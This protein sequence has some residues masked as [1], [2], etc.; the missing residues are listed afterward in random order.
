ME[1]MD[2]VMKQAEQREPDQ[3]WGAEDKLRRDRERQEQEGRK[4]IGAARRALVDKLAL[5]EKHLELLQAPG[6]LERTLAIEAVSRPSLLT[7]LSG[8]PGTGKTT[9]AVSWLFQWVWDEKSW[10]VVTEGFSAKAAFCYAPGVFVTAA[11]LARFSRYDE[12]QMDELLRAGRLVIDDLGAEF[13]DVKGSFLSLLDEVVNERYANRRPTVLTT[14]LG[15][16]AFKERYGERIADRIV[17]AGRFVSL[18]N[19]SMR[20]RGEERPRQGNLTSVRAPAGLPGPDP[21][22]G[23]KDDDDAP[24]REFI[25]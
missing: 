14:N 21:R 24:P 2:K 22:T 7:V 18:G 8:G 25:P 5:P 10:R 1:D 17:E 15:V 16:L 9:A 23:E 19:E 6:D 11:R 13:L 4:A 12:R 3:A 20:R